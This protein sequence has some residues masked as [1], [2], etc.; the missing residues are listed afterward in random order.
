MLLSGDQEGQG[1]LLLVTEVSRAIPSAQTLPP[2]GTVDI[3]CIPG[4]FQ[5]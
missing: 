2:E 1:T 3:V 5:D 4:T